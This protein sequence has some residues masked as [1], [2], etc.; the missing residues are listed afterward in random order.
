MSDQIRVNGNL[1]SWGSIICKVDGDLLCGFTSITFGDT[2]ERVKGYGMA[3]HHVPRG[4]SAGKYS[5]EAGKLGG[6]LDA[7]HALR[8]K[9]AS[10]APDRISYGNVEFLITV[11]YVENDLLPLHIDLIRC[12]IVKDTTS[13][14]E[15]A[16]PLKGELEFD[17]FY[18]LRNGLA[19]F[20]ASKGL[21]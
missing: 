2:R 13:H 7:V 5:T 1:F 20:D 21:P 8:T 16:D 18:I 17:Y 10:L 6:A 4:R 15:S 19:L 14:E 12:V 9:L 3:R 11:Q